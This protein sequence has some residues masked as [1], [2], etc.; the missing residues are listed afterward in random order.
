MSGLPEKLVA[1]WNETLNEPVD[2]FLE[3]LAKLDGM[4]PVS[5]VPGRGE[6]TADE[7]TPG[8]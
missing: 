3:L 4:P 5:V 8:D 1:L 2:P 7:P 6:E